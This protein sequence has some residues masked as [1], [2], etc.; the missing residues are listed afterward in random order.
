MP[1]SSEA[2]LVEAVQRG[3]LGSFGE[4][5]GLYYKPMVAIAYSVL[6][7][8]QL[9]EDAVQ[10]AFA[11]GLRGMHSLRR[12]ECFGGWLARICRNVAVRMAKARRRDGNAADMW[13]LP[14]RP[15]KDE[16]GLAVRRCLGRLKARDREI[17]VLKYYDN[18][19]HDQ[20]AAVLRLSPAAVHGRLQR[21]RRRLAGVMR[22]EGVV[23]SGS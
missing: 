19:S 6:G 12:T 22:R 1:D 16:V 5:C 9:A 14:A 21:A 11:R 13:S 18:L 4:L 2:H 20:I 8:H 3:D 23:E 10:E 7:D 17:M 15:E